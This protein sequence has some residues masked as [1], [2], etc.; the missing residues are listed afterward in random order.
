MVVEGAPRAP[1]GVRTFFDP[2]F[3]ALLSALPIEWLL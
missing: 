3:V 2:K 1:W